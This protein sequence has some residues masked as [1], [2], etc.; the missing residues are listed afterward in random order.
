MAVQE[1]TACIKYVG[2]NSSLFTQSRPCD[3]TEGLPPSAPHS[4]SPRVPL[5]TGVRHKAILLTFGRRD[6]A[7][8]KSGREEVN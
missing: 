1:K 5:P 7:E 3:E 2:T 8:Q 6:A 4:Y